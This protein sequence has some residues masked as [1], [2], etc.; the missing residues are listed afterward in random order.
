[1]FVAL[2]AMAPGAMAQGVMVPHDQAASP[3]LDEHRWSVG[4][5]VGVMTVHTTPLFNLEVPVEYTMP[6][7]PGDLAFHAGFMLSVGGDRLIANN[8]G[9]RRAR[10]SVWVGLPFGARYKIRVLDSHPL[11][12]WPMM[13]FGPQF[14]TWNGDAAGFFR[15]GAGVSYLVHPHVELLFR[16]ITVGAVFGP[17][18][19][20]FL[21]N[22]TMGANFRF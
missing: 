20:W 18:G 16:P 3:R 19:G 1:V 21:Y 2:T 7:G 4:T 8:L 9:I 10:S 22:M 11:Y 12:V 17:G 6:L 14:D 15:T 5:E 13:D